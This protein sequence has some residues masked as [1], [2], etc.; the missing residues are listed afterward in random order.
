MTMVKQRR[1]FFV[2]DILHRVLP[3]VKTSDRSSPINDRKRKRSITSDDDDDGGDGHHQENTHEPL[4]TK[5]FRSYVH[6]EKNHEPSK[7]SPIVDVLGHNGPGDESSFDNERSSFSNHSGEEHRLP[8]RSR[9][10]A[11][12]YSL[13]RSV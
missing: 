7:H 5:K 1:S 11:S 8:V 12:F 4:P 10:I 13:H 6:T 3:M 2:D 9:R